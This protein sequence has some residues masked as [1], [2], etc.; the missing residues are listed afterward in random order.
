MDVHVSL[1][2]IEEG[3]AELR[4]GRY[5]EAG[6]LALDA[7]DAAVSDAEF[8]AVTDFAEEAIAVCGFMQ[9]GR[10]EAAL[11]HLEEQRSV[12]VLAAT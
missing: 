4:A 1:R 6:R 12:G 9:R 8:E 3:R 2:L 10:F 11:E 5:R 7:A